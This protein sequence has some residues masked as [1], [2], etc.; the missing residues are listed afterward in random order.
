MAS[1]F[2]PSRSLVG[3][4]ALVT[5]AVSLAASP[6]VALAQTSNVA[7][8]TLQTVAYSTSSSGQ[9]PFAGQDIDGRSL[10]SAPDGTIRAVAPQYGGGYGGGNYHRYSDN[11]RLSHLAFEAGGGFTA[12]IG[13]DVNGGFTTLLAAPGTPAEN[14]GT[15][16]YGGNFLV[17]AGWNFSK[18]FA[19]L[20]EYSWNTN[21]IPGRTLSAV[22]NEGG[23]AADD[24]YSI[25]GNVHTQG[26]TAEPVF[27][28]YNSDKHNYAGYVIGGGGYYHKS[29]N[30]TAPVE[31]ETFYGDYIV[32]ETFSTYTN[33][34]IGFNLGTGISFKPFGPDSRAKLFAEARYVFVDSPRETAA[35]ISNQNILNTG[36]E[37]YIPVT[38]G[39]RF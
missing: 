15:D 24:L 8:P 21:K 28:Y 20:G 25:G 13:N 33:N 9:N 5:A 38:V 39:L 17:G 26:I 36:T 27:Y 34:S 35:D 12:P 6:A 32:T 4:L 3:H 19:L 30:F 10:G 14:Y 1:L 18:R 11:S 2:T 16:T 29:T 23:F 31:E 7:A 22:Y 37:E